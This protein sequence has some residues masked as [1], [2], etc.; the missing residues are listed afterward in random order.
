MNRLDGETVLI[1]GAAKGLG[2]AI[3]R[4]FVAEGA[5]VIATDIDEAGL[6]AL[7]PEVITRRLDVSSERD[8]AD[9]VGGLRDVAP[10]ISVLVNNAAIC[11]P[12]PLE[13]ESLEH[14]MQVALVNQAGVFLGIREIAP[15]MRAQGRGSI[16]NISSIEGIVA[17]GGLLSYT[18]SKFAVLGITKAAASELGPHGIRVNALSPGAIQTPM[19][20][21]E[22]F[23]GTDWE[24]FIG[25]IALGRLP[26][27]DEVAKTALF[28]ASDDSSYSSAS[29]FVVDGG[30]IG[31]RPMPLKPGVSLPLH[32]AAARR[33]ADS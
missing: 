13:L 22:A 3:V 21:D 9:V 15:I 24:T 30:L 32:P 11:E 19:V 5:T 16:V 20:N 10:P 33:P 2:E 25:K 6:K 7:G 8:W 31:Q 28:L 4:L 17:V 29:D 18:A 26:S 23:D 1:T 12:A 14:F 27:P